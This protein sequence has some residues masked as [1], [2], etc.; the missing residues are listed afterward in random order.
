MKATLIVA[1]ALIAILPASAQVNLLANSS[2]NGTI[3]GWG[4]IDFTPAYN[5]S[6]SDGLA[7]E[8]SL[9][10]NGPVGG[11]GGDWGISQA[12]AWAG[13][14]TYDVFRLGR[15]YQSGWNELELRV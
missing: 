9:Q 15:P 10:V 8:Q 2:L 5:S 7:G 11:G 12:V 13:A 6:R 14:G 3:T 1:I 4:A